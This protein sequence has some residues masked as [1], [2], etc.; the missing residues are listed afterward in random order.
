M[1]KATFIKNVGVFGNQSPYIEL[2]YEN[3]KYV[4]ITKEKAGLTATWNQLF[5]FKY[6]DISTELKFQAFGK[7]TF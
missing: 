1:I 2:N 7:N 5:E 6:P 3:K 4:S